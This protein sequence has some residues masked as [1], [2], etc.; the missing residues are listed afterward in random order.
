MKS[1]VRRC[2]RAAWRTLVAYGATQTALPFPADP[3]FSSPPPANGPERLL[4]DQPLTDL[5][6]FLTQELAG[7][8][9]SGA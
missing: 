3:L 6:R 7:R 2:A 9:R 5:E 4:P 8:G 1:F